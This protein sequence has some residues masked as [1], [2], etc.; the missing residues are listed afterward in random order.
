MDSRQRDQQKSPEAQEGELDVAT[1]VS[2]L[3]AKP[4]RRKPPKSNQ[5]L[6]TQRA[7]RKNAKKA[8]EAHSK[9]VQTAER[10]HEK[11]YNE[12]YGSEGFVDSDCFTALVMAMAIATVSGAVALLIYYEHI[13]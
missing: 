1:P 11:R 12:L 5:G 2:T 6:S 8:L 10:K 7:Y 4:R 13:T 9:R 3:R